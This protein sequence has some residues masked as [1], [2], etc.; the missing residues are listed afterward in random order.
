MNPLWNRLWTKFRRYKTL[1]THTADNTKG[2]NNATST[3][4]FRP[5]WK[6]IIVE[7]PVKVIIEL[8]RNILNSHLQKYVC[9]Q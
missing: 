6:Q 4:S 9:W 7:L 3:A 1:Y 2:R 8:R 5:L